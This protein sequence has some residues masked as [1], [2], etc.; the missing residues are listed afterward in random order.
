V[1][2]MS[3]IRGHKIRGRNSNNKSTNEEAI[4]KNRIRLYRRAWL[5][6]LRID[7]YSFEQQRQQAEGR[8]R[9]SSVDETGL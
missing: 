9:D 4:L 3:P 1:P 6:R 2:P 5:S 7:L 8:S